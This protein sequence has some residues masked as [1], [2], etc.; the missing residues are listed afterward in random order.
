MTRAASLPAMTANRTP[1]LRAATAVAV[2][3]R[4]AWILLPAIDSEVSTA[5]TSTPPFDAS[6]PAS[7]A[8]IV[9]TAWTS[10]ASLGRYSFWK[11]ERSKSSMSLFLGKGQDCHRLGTVRRQGALP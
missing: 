3:W 6:W 1:S 4:A 2:A 10:L 8:V 9:I 7:G 5:M 11:H